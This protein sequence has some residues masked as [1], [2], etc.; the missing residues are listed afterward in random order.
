MNRNLIITPTSNMTDAEW[1]RFRKRGIGASEV[2][3]I[4]GL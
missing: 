4:L 2:G 1:L 3:A